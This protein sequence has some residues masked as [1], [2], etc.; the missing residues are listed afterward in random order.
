MSISDL[1]ITR[2]RLYEYYT[3]GGL[4]NTDLTA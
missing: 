4:K 3:V 2:I 1:K